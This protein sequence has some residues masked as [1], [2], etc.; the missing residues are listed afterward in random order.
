[1]STLRAELEGDLK[2]TSPS[3]LVAV[4]FGSVTPPA[5]CTGTNSQVH[6]ISGGTVVLGVP[7]TPG[8]LLHR[9]CTY[10]NACSTKYSPGKLMSR[11]LSISQPPTMSCTFP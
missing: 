7:G 3:G 5:S 9:V 2:V 10:D 6:A 1:M 11:C 8:C 4:T